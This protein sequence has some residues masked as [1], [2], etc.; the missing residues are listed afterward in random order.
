MSAVEAATA[1]GYAGV[2]GGDS[3]MQLASSGEEGA[4]R[5]G[6]ATPGGSRH[7]RKTAFVGLAAILAVAAY[8]AVALRRPTSVGGGAELAAQRDGD[9]SP[10]QS[11]SGNA[12]QPPDEHT[13]V[14][15]SPAYP[16]GDVNAD[17][18][19]YEE[20]GATAAALDIDVPAPL[21]TPTGDDHPA[22]LVTASNS[23]LGDDA[24]S[25]TST[26]DASSGS[27]A[28]TDGAAGSEGLGFS[29]IN[30]YTARGDAPVG[31]GY[32]WV[33][34]FYAGGVVEPHRETTLTAT[35][36]Y[37]TDPHDS[38]KVTYVWT[39]VTNVTV[40]SGGGSDA[41][42]TTGDDSTELM[43]VGEKAIHTFDTPGQAYRIVLTELAESSKAEGRID[44]GQATR[45]TASA[46]VVCKYVRR[47]LRRLT[48]TDREIFF[49]AM[50]V[51]YSVSTN[52]GQKMF[53]THDGLATHYKSAHDFVEL[54]NTLSGQ[55]DC[56]HLHGGLGFLTQHAAMT[57]SF[58]LSLQSI[59]SRLSMPYWDYS[60]DAARSAA[61]LRADENADALKVWYQSEVFQEDWFGPASPASK[62]IDAGRFAYLSVHKHPTNDSESVVPGFPLVTNAYG[63]TRSPWNMN[64]VPYV[65][66][67]NQSY[68]F[69]LDYTILPGCSDMYNQMLQPLWSQFGASIQYSPHGSLHIAIGGTWGADYAS[70]LTENDNF[71]YRYSKAQPMGT[72]TMA[73]TWR[74]GW[75]SCPSSCSH[76]TPSTECKCTCG[77]VHEYIHN[78]RSSD[79]IS[80]M[81][82]SLAAAAHFTISDEG[83]DISDT[84]LRLVCN[85]YEGMNPEVGDFMESASPSDP[86]F[87]PTHPTLDR[88][89]HWRSINGFSDESWDSSTCWGHNAEDVTVWKKG[90]DAVQI[91]QGGGKAGTSEEGT[92]DGML[93]GAAGLASG[94]STLDTRNGYYTNAELYTKFSASNRLLPYVY[95]T[96]EWEH[97]EAE[98][99]PS[100]LLFT[101]SDDGDDRP[102]GI[103]GAPTDDGEY[104]NHRMYRQ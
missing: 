62:A 23:P 16:D 5:D 104:I 13:S 59:D 81:Y 64:K 77:H 27:G 21:D 19:M 87:W 83:T 88:L 86:L 79:I 92:I 82:P 28:G 91:S 85:D 101:P 20:A 55:D 100:N 26:D 80:K 44:I 57:H 69:P 72:I 25:S 14:G 38:A 1:R 74:S 71:N 78:N 11:S 18:G 95:D 6:D 67:H 15:S 90:Y 65:T 48:D 51:L 35:G 42:W 61:A 73:R 58:E 46:L 41:T 47:E 40:S 8:G 63:L 24:A 53:A 10:R 93:L 17:D 4:V 2:D 9:R 39:I 3:G 12:K 76:D 84:L 97:C 30:E 32:H 34:D 54:H 68:G 99:Y 89:W 70:F 98:G 94:M 96:F 45:R 102:M 29:L 66:R 56:D 36:A 33:V 22:E 50:A 60:I 75:L 31:T 7:M 43:Y 49:E 37:D 52:V 103:A